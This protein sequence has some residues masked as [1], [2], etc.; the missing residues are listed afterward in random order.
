ME[1]GKNHI[2]ICPMCFH[3]NLEHNLVRRNS[4]SNL[5]VLKVRYPRTIHEVI[6]EI[7]SDDYNRDDINEYKKILHQLY[8]I[9]IR[10]DTETKIIELDGYTG[11]LDI[12]DLIK[13]NNNKK[14]FKFI[15]ACNIN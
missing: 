7:P 9:D 12:G 15:N 2:C 6:D 5:T 13:H 4:L 1:S 10:A 11:Y 14:V 3:H 8:E